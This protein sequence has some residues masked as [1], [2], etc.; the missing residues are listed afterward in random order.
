MDRR[1]WICMRVRKQAQKGDLK[2]DNQMRFKIK[3]D[4]GQSTFWYVKK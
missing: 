4:Y 3:V 1:L 2:V